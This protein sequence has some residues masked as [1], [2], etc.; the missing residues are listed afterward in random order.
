MESGFHAEGTG[1]SGYLD[2]V[3]ESK[4]GTVEAGEE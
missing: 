4:F 1:G 3:N 2:P